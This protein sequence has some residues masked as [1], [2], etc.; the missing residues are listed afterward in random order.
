[1]PRISRLLRPAFSVGPVSKS[2]PRRP[3]GLQWSSIDFA[4][5][6][7]K[8]HQFDL[9]DYETRYNVWGQNKTIVHG[10]IRIRLD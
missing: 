6:E 10:R 7:R 1:M 3:V 5:A 2:T 4:A 8:V 9:K